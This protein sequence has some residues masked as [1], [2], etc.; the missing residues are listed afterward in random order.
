MI[1]TF[2]FNL[3]KGRV[4]VGGAFWILESQQNVNQAAVGPRVVQFP[5]PEASRL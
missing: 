3:S 1:I 2:L 5:S 4:G